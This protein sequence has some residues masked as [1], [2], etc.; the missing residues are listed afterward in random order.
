MKGTFTLYYTGA[1]IKATKLRQN[2][3]QENRK[4]TDILSD[5]SINFGAQL[6]QVHQK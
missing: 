2:S 5:N 3:K 4:T 1:V 6:L